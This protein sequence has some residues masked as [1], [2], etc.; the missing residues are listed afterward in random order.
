MEIR[1]VREPAQPRGSLAGTLAVLLA[2]CL[3]ATS[4]T[5]IKHLIQGY[6]L[7]PLTVAAARIALAA[8]MLFVAL[9]ALNRKQLRIQVRDIPFFLLFGLICVTLFQACWVYAVSLID[10]GV[11]TVLNYTAPAWAALF[12]WPLLGERIDRRKGLALLLTAAGVALIVR[13]FD[14]DFLSLNVTGLLWGLGSGVT[15]GLYGIFSRR[16]LGRYSFW[17]IITYTFAAGA[18]FLLATQLVLSL[19][20]TPVEG[21]AEAS[22]GGMGTAFVQPSAVLWLVILALFPTVV[23]YALYTFGLRFLEATVAAIL[24]TVEPVMAALWATA[25]LGEWLTWPQI[26]GGGLVIA[27]VIALQR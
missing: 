16:A 9:G 13:I 8:L 12:A 3:F 4:G 18:L 27:G 24:A 6:G 5:I 15:Y 7:P 10:V 22:V 2:A 25:F 26:I 19:A 11:A 14:A 20:L 23:G 1:E 17:T 21:S